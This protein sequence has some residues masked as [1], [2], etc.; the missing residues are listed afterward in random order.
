MTQKNELVLMN[1]KGVMTVEGM[2]RIYKA[3][4][5]KNFTPDYRVLV[6]KKIDAHTAKGK[7]PHRSDQHFGSADRT[8]D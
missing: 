5:G 4:T 1:G 6:Q 7:A 3:L 8:V 2:E